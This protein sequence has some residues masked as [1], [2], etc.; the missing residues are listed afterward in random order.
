M[1]E[2]QKLIIAYLG[3]Q[4][5]EFLHA[6]NTILKRLGILEENTTDEIL[7]EIIEPFSLYY[8]DYLRGNYNLDQMKKFLRKEVRMALINTSKDFPLKAKELFLQNLN[9]HIQWV[10]LY[11]EPIFFNFDTKEEL[12]DILNSARVIAVKLN[13]EPEKVF[14]NSDNA[15]YNR[16]L[17][18]LYKTPEKLKEKLENLLIVFSQEKVIAKIIIPTIQS[19]SDSETAEQK[20][21]AERNILSAQMAAKNQTVL[22]LYFVLK[23]VIQERV[24]K[25]LSS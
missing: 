8:P 11:A 19:L 12:V 3:R 21:E 23:N 22:E 2:D 20:L 1:T 17:K 5:G 15:P 14:I 6:K 25:I 7:S 24:V 4:L 9:K 13:L 16:L 10:Y 18:N